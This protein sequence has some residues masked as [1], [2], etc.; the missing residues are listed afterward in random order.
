MNYAQLCMEVFEGNQDLPCKPPHD[1]EWDTT[2]L[3][4]LDERQE[5]VSE[6]LPHAETFNQ[7]CE[8]AEKLQ[9]D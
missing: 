3:E 1:R 2:I 7:C 5:I 4:F 6:H 8:Q 9:V